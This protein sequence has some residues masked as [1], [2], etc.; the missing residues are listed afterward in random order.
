MS[1]CCS[2]DGVI[3]VQEA[4]APGSHT[5]NTDW[6]GLDEV[7]D[8]HTWHTLLSRSWVC[9]SF[10]F[11]AQALGIVSAFATNTC[12]C[13]CA[14]AKPA[15]ATCQTE[16]PQLAP[17]TTLRI[18]T[19]LS[20]DRCIHRFNLSTLILPAFLFPVIYLTTLIITPSAPSTAVRSFHNRILISEIYFWAVTGHK[21]KHSHSTLHRCLSAAAARLSSASWFCWVMALVARPVY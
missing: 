1:A 16:T 21:Q 14:P 2:A 7:M 6:Q 20:L 13:A 9:Y 12:A 18:Y 15:A 4:N 11:R 10:I 19:R 17:S 3:L 8:G 5:A